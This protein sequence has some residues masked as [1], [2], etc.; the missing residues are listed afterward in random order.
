LDATDPWVATHGF[1]TWPH[2]GRKI[3]DL[4]G[5]AP[6]RFQPVPAFPC[7]Q[8]L[9]GNT[10]SRSSASGFIT[11]KRTENGS[12]KRVRN[13]SEVGPECDRGCEAETVHHPAIGS[14]HLFRVPER[15]TFV[16]GLSAVSPLAAFARRIETPCPSS[17]FPP[18]MWGCLA[19]SGAPA[20]R[21][22]F[23]S[24][25]RS[26]GCR[27]RLGDKPKVS[28]TNSGIGS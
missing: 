16:S 1:N 17:R 6:A 13:L 27:L 14:W 15:R 20:A 21:S 26:F 8:A 7:S 12:D 3:Q 11:R 23:R 9:L 5:E 22:T 25:G 24:A 18:A 10:F 4:R 19:G 28:G 2:R